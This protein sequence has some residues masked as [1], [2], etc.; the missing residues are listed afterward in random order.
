MTASLAPTHTPVEPC[1]TERDKALNMAFT[2]AMEGGV[3]YWSTCSRYHWS[4][5]DGRT[6]AKDF[7]AVVHD[8]Y[9]ED[10]PPAAHVIDRT[11]IARGIRKAYEHKGWTEY[12]M[13]ALRMLNFGR[14][15]DH[16]DIDMDADTGDL[17]VQ[18]GLFG[19][20]VYA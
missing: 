6:E 17:I 12:H 7:I 18:F 20:Q 11:V 14:Y 5:G 13:T 9:D 15:E 4:L 19:E 3:G 1:A 10:E 16:L 2:T 8:I